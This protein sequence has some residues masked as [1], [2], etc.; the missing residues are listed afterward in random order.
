MRRYKELGLNEIMRKGDEFMCFGGWIKCKGWIGSKR[1]S[2]AG[3]PPP[4]V[5]RPL[6]A[7]EAVATANNKRIKQGPK[8]AH[9]KR[10]S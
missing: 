4:R 2:L 7:K 6:K 10:T 9:A 8:R 3:T 5:R 1:K